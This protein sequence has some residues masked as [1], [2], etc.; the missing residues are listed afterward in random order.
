MVTTASF[1]AGELVRWYENYHDLMSA[2]DT[3][4]GIIVEKTKYSFSDHSTSYT[5]YKVYRT[6]HGDIMYFDINDLIKVKQEK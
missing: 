6:T 2:K 4:L 1:K 3:G 5:N